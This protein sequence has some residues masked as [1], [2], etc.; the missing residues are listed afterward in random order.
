MPTASDWLTGNGAEK[1][2]DG[3]GPRLGFLVIL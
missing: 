2:M 3:N 1:M